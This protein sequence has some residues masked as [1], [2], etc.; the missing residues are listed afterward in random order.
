M[1]QPR[2][3]QAVQ[4]SSVERSSPMRHGLSLRQ[5]PVHMGSS[6][7]CPAD[8]EP[9]VY[10]RTRSLTAAIV[11]SYPL[12]GPCSPLLFASSSNF[13]LVSLSNSV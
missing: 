12:S 5:E 7:S 9:F 11:S 3:G 6:G 4:S 10:P 1:Y 13:S 8:S 2:L